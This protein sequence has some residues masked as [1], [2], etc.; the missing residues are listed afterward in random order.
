MRIHAV[1]AVLLLIVGCGADGP[2]PTEMA[3]DAALGPEDLARPPPPDVAAAMT[4]RLRIG[5]ASL[6]A[7]DL[8]AVQVSAD[9]A[10][11][12]ALTADGLGYVDARGDERRVDWT[13]VNAVYLVMYQPAAMPHMSEADREPK[14]AYLVQVTAPAVHPLAETSGLIVVDAGTGALEL[15]MAPCMGRLCR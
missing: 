10:V 2:E 1:L 6:T 9:E 4:T 5:I 14:P 3:E 8:R 15:Q 13:G 12:T 11:A 7:R